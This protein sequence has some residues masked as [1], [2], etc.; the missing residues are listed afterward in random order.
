MRNLITGIVIKIKNLL[1]LQ[2]EGLYIEHERMRCSSPCPKCGEKIN[3]GY[4]KL[5]KPSSIN[6]SRQQILIDYITFHYMEK[7]EIYPKGLWA[8]NVKL[9]D[10]IS[11]NE[12][13]NPR[14]QLSKAEL[15]SQK[16]EF[17]LEELNKKI[18]EMI[19]E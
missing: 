12:K 8:S 4:I 14:D 15:Q 19:N 2:K 1:E 6:S 7:H 3:G 5:L 17:S 9:E 11:T 18:N 10:L 13:K 16:K